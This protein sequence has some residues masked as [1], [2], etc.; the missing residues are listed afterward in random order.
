MPQY[1]KHFL[2]SLLTIYILTTGYFLLTNPITSNTAA[3]LTNLTLVTLFICRPW[4]FWQ[5]EYISLILFVSR[6]LKEFLFIEIPEN[7]DTTNFHTFFLSLSLWIFEGI[8]FVFIFMMAAIILYQ[9]YISFKESDLDTGAFSPGLAP[10]KIAELPVIQYSNY[11]KQMEHNHSTCESECSIC[12]EA[13]ESEDNVNTLY[14]CQ[15]IYHLECIKKWLIGHKN[16]PYCRA[17][18]YKTESAIDIDEDIKT[19]HEEN[20][21]FSDFMVATGWNFNLL[22]TIYNS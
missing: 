9:L 18:V 1:F 8:F 11:K 15:H 2:L 4:I 12:L 22:P 20:S 21:T 3:L 13:F 10:E 14:N 16:C 7:I 19:T 6:I 17:R 5:C